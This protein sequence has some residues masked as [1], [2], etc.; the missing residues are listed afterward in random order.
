MSLGCECP[1]P[2]V[3]PNQIDVACPVDFDQITRLAFQLNQGV[4][5][6]FVTAEPITD[7]DSW[8]A[9]LAASGATKVVLSPA[10]SSAVIPMSE[11]TYE[12]ENSNDSLNGLGYYL[13]ENNIR[14]TAMVVSAP[15]SVMDALEALS[16]YSDTTLGSSKLTAFFMT[17]RIRGKAGILAKTGSAAGDYAGIEIFNFRVSSVGSEG[18]KAK[19]KYMIAFDMQPDELKGTELV[20]VDWNPLLLANVATS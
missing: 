9:L 17:R 16:C 4:T 15:Q 5:P 8:T 7:V 14:F 11:G 12:G 3:I 20:K 2:S 13:G 1:L 6:S 10:L 19:N 18:Y